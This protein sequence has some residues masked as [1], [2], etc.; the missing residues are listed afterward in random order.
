MIKLFGITSLII[1][2]IL[3]IFMISF[4]DEPGALP[5]LLVI[6]GITA[7]VVDKVRKKRT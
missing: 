7:S 1:G 2:T 6:M 3:L 4:E 5:L